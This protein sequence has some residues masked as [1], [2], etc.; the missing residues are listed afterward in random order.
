MVVRVKYW[1]AFLLRKSG[2]LFLAR[3]RP[4]GGVT[5]LCY[6]RVF[7][8]PRS[9]R[10]YCFPGMAISRKMF[11][12]QMACLAKYYHVV[13]LSHAVECLKSGRSLP[14]GAVVITFDDG[15]MD[16]YL[17]AYPVLQKYELPATFFLVSEF[18]GGK[19]LLWFDRIARLLDCAEAGPALPALFRTHLPAALSERASALM[20]AHAASRPQKISAVVG[21]LKGAP[22]AAVAGLVEALAK[23][24]PAA[25]ESAGADGGMSW[26]MLREMTRNG[27]DVGSHTQ[28]HTILTGL[29]ADRVEHEIGESK[30]QL[31]QQLSTTV[32][33]FC[34]PNG[35]FDDRIWKN[36]ARHG[37]WAA[38]ALR[39]GS[40]K[41][42][43]DL[44][45]LRRI[46]INEAFSADL[47]GDF[48]ENVFM[49]EL[50][51]LFDWVLLRRFRRGSPSYK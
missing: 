46:N 6:H 3:R 2:I 35:N 37:F 12:A 13:C 9:M 39:Y 42:A 5:I 27:M 18:M 22:A 19:S 30:R 4:F 10:D 36:L 41:S 31:E 45:A 50:A 28:T 24:F 14:V 43:N 29:P 49:A 26:E 15:Y 48:S 51:G 33:W 40:N 47:F 1:L 44:T 38:C 11:D 20:A 8:D 23:Q 34:Y 25:A 32:R 16:N 7:N 21:L 17:Y